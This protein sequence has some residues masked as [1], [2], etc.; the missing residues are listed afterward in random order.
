MVGVGEGAEGSQ[1]PESVPVPLESSF[2][3]GEE[4]GDGMGI[5]DTELHSF[6]SPV[7]STS[8]GPEHSPVEPSLAVRQTKRPRKPKVDEDFEYY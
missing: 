4:S 2:E 8:K 3:E 1:R 7:P 5:G 6:S